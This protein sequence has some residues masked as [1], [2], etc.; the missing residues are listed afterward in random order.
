MFSQNRLTITTVGRHPEVCIVGYLYSTR[1]IAQWEFSNE[2]ID[3]SC[4][5][6][7]FLILLATKWIDHENLPRQRFM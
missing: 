2:N 1:K 6:V 7:S 5:M 3:N 4:V